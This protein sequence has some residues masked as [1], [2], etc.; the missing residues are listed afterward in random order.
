MA[1]ERQRTAGDLIAGNDEALRDFG[2]SPRP[3]SPGDVI[4]AARF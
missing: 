3:F 2:Y 4:A 1:T